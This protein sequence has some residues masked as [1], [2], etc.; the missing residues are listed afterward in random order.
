MTE[1][2][3]VYPKLEEL[4]TEGNHIIKVSP[5]NEWDKEAGAFK[6]GTLRQGESQYGKWYI[7]RTKVGGEWVSM[8][9]N[10]E[11]K[12]YFEMGYV[13]AVIVPKRLKGSDDDLF[14]ATGKKLLKA[15]FNKLTP[16]ELEFAIAEESGDLVEGKEVK[17][18]VEKEISIDDIKF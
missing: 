5:Q 17:P 12:A 8:F 3:K 14:D 6:E 1:E 7:F 11:N 4:L 9:A 15:F 2:K 13:K 10:D 16:N 18:V